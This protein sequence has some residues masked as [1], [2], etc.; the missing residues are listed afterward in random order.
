MV[1]GSPIGP[2]FS[3]AGVT[4]AS[5]PFVPMRSFVFF[6]FYIDEINPQC[7]GSLLATPQQV[8]K[9]FS[10]VR[11]RGTRA[12]GSNTPVKMGVPPLP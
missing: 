5:N 7:K 9:P 10:S 3:V 12:T 8:P 1:G 2:V 6:K 11:Y 4:R